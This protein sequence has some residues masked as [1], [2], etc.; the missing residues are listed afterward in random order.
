MKKSKTVAQQGQTKLSAFFSPSS[1]EK[2]SAS[3]EVV[4]I[5]D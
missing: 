1:K 4:E 2:P 3:P 5:L